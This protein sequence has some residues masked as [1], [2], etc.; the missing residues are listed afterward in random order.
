MV[1][2]LILFNNGTGTSATPTYES[3]Q[4]LSAGQA[5]NVYLSQLCLV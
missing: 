1:E 2:E 4:L 5:G 3:D